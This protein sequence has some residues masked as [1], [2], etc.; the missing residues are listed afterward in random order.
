MIKKGWHGKQ[1][2]RNE[3]NHIICAELKNIELLL[4]INQA[5]QKH[6]SPGNKCQIEHDRT[7]QAINHECVRY[8]ALVEIKLVVGT[9]QNV[10]VN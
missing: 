8:V 9:V 5:T 4:L 3:K 7:K 6:G 1:A 10:N 2:N